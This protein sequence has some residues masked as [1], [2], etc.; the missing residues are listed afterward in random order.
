MSARAPR[1][2]AF[3]L[4]EALVS[5]FIFGLIS[6]GCVAMLMQSVD[7]QRRVGEAQEALREVQVARALIEADLQ[8]I[9]PRPVREADGRVRPAF[10]GGDADTALAFVRAAAEPD[11][12]R[13][14]VT[15]LAFVEYRIEDG[16]LMRR[17]RAYLDA[18]ANTPVAE[19]V[20]LA[21]AD[22]MHFEF[23]DGRA[24]REQ[25]LSASRAEPLPRAVALVFKA[26]R[27]GDVRIEALLGLS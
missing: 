1:D 17:S 13:G 10:I 15:S 5:L 23:Y 26:P 4:V 7:S 14:M 27:Y 24:W 6:A 2:A 8:Q 25:W 21:H 9:A 11:A 16:R 12:Q 20:V 18:G 3:T 22:D 19:R